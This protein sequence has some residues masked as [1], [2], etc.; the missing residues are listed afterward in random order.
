MKKIFLIFIL[1]LS[2]NLNLHAGEKYKNSNEKYW[3]DSLEE[4]ELCAST[5]VCDVHFDE[6][7]KQPL[8]W[9]GKSYF[10]PKEPENIAYD[11]CLLYTSPSPRDRTRS[12]MPSSA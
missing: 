8:L 1:T 4:A 12:R 11:G 3:I 7:E 2:I 9:I 10:D 5:D 6:L